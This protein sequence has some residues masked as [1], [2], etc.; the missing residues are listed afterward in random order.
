MKDNRFSERQ[1]KFLQSFNKE[2]IR[3]RQDTFSVELRRNKRA[4]H[5]T[6]KRLNCLNTD[7][8]VDSENHFNSVFSQNLLEYCPGLTNKDLN[9]VEKLNYLNL[10]LESNPEMHILEAAITAVKNI[11]GKNNSPDI[12]IFIHLGF[13]EKIINLLDRHY[14]PTITSEAS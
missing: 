14:G 3:Q 5:R 2:E 8:E 10:V 13:P 1:V 11:I 9:Q 12:G 4:L 6:K 7:I